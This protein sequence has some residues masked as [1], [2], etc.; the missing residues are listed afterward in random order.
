M[1]YPITVTDQC[2][3]NNGGC[4]QLCLLTQSGRVCACSGGLILDDDGRNCKGMAYYHQKGDK[5]SP[6]K[7]FH[8]KRIKFRLRILFFRKQSQS[9]ITGEFQTPKLAFNL[10]NAGV[11]YK[12]SPKVDD[13]QRLVRAYNDQCVFSFCY[14]ALHL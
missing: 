5:F 9:L 11:N 2:N 8:S 7:L 14:H 4:S 6:P 1:L 10:L 3:N 12:T 13:K